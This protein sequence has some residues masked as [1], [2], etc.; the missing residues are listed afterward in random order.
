[1]LSIALVFIAKFHGVSR[2][3]FFQFVLSIAFFLSIWRVLKRWYVE[4]LVASGYNNQN[5]LIVGAGQAGK[6][7]AQELS[8]QQHLGL[9]VI[10]FLDDHRKTEEHTSKGKILGKTSELERIVNEKF[11]D[12]VSITFPLQRGL[13]NKIISQ[14]R[15]L[16]VGVKI[17]PEYFENS[18]SRLDIS[19]IGRIPLLEYY[20]KPELEAE[21]MIKRLID[22]VF[23]FVGLLILSPLFI[24]IAIL[25]KLDSPG[26]IFYVSPRI[27]RKGKIFKFYKFRSMYAGAE[28]DLDKLSERNEKDGPIFKM[29]N[30]PRETKIGRFIRKY[31]ID[32]LSQLWNVLKGDMSLVGP[33]PPTPSEIDRYKDWELKR[34]NVIPGMT[35]PYV[36]QGR[37]NLSFGEW[38]RSDLDYIENWSLGLDLKILLKTVPA[39]IKGEG[40]Y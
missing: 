27:G 37:S 18:T 25:I 1:M 12:Q 34:V 10:G 36:I 29:E 38:V 30:D 5:V 7:L 6:S 22:I 35:S 32:E 39:I 19:Y 31:S 8:K 40:A 4:D 11:I 21:L 33:R 26:P 16:G 15:K 9:K 14:A 23:S 24:A 28:K 3:V 17:I 20:G 2:L 13:A